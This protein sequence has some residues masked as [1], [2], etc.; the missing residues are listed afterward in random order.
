M[1]NTA[2]FTPIWA[3]PSVLTLPQYLGAAINI[4][5]SLVLPIALILYFIRKA[6]PR[7]ALTGAL[8]FIVSQLILRIPLL[9]LFTAMNQSWLQTLTPQVPAYYVYILALSLTAGLFEEWGRYLFMRLML[10]QRRSTTDALAF[11]AG[12]GGIEAILLVGLTVTVQLFFTPQQFESLSGFVIVIGGVERVFAMLFHIAMSVLIMRRGLAQIRFVWLA[13]LLHTLLNFVPIAL[14]GLLALT[15]MANILFTEGMLL[16][17]AAASV[18]Y[19]VHAVRNPHTQQAE[20]QV[21][22]IAK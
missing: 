20:E 1:S 22:S 2:S 11:G 3:G 19:I 16:L 14:A 4:L 6:G 21:S 15:G 7:P 9:Q 5:L 10:K 13:V 12:H 17:G 8:C 18:W